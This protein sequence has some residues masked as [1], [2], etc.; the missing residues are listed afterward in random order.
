MNIEEYGLWFKAN[1]YVYTLDY[2][3]I[4][5][6]WTNKLIWAE[7]KKVLIEEAKIASANNHYIQI[8][9]VCY[10][11]DDMFYDSDIYFTVGIHKGLLRFEEVVKEIFPNSF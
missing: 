10:H 3:K 1:I 11:N 6:E 9:I 4:K 5:Y 2:V 8:K 7:L